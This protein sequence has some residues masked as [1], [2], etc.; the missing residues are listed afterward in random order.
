MSLRRSPRLKAKQPAAPTCDVVAYANSILQFIRMSQAA[1]YMSDERASLCI[2]AFEN[3]MATTEV[4]AYYPS[5][6]NTILEAIQRCCKS[7]AADEDL[8]GPLKAAMKKYR[9]F[10]VA[11]RNDS[12]YRH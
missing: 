10:L 1:P 7:T 9:K 2:S 12:H 6:R 3:A 4:I 8:G 11:V 5:L